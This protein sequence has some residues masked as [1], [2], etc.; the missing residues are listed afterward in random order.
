MLDR[1]PP[2]GLSS[3]GH[4]FATLGNDVYIVRAFG[5][6]GAADSQDEAPTWLSVVPNAL[7]ILLRFLADFSGCAV[8]GSSLPMA[9]RETRQGESDRSKSRLGSNHLPRG[10]SAQRQNHA[11]SHTQDRVAGLEH[12]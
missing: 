12:A 6:S 8:R 9:N 11:R 5:P 2:G 3:I 1:L 4:R 10:L 7:L